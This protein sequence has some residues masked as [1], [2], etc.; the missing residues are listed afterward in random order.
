MVSGTIPGFRAADRVVDRDL[1]RITEAGIE[2][3]RGLTVGTDLTMDDLRDDGFRYLVAAAG[4]QKGIGLGIPG[5]DAAGVWDGLVFLGAART[6]QLMDLTG[7]VGVVGGGDVAM[8]CA[9]TARRLGA[10]HVELIY[11]RSVAEM[12]ALRDEIEALDREG[13][14]VREVTVPHEVISRDGR[15]VALK[16]KNTM[17]GA[18]DDSGRRRPIV[19]WGSD[20]EIPLDT[21][22]V[23]IGQRADLALFVGDDVRT[24]GRRFRRGRSGHHGDLHPRGV[25]RR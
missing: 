16:A 22:V 12:P 14:P 18:P 25:R 5:E 23:A 11:R 24:N 2:V 7:R 9:R 6:G 19:M 3:R 21:L 13:I 20:H 8:D 1:D 15:I 4:A 17:L 10:E